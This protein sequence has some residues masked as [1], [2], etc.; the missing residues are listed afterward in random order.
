M[1]R[2]IRPMRLVFMGTP[3]FAVPALDA[4]I[5]AGHHIVCV[6]TQPPRR[7]GRGQAERPSPVHIHADQNGIKVRCPASLKDEETQAEFAALNADAAI[8]VAYGLILP[9]EIL[10]APRLGCLNIHASLLP[11]W[12]GAAPI[13]RAIMEGDEVT[14]VNIM[15]MDEGLDTGPIILGAETPITT[16]TSGGALHDSLAALGAVLVV[17]A[18]AGRD[19]GTLTATRQPESGATYARKLTRDDGRLDW[20]LPAETLE[21]RVRALSPLPGAWFNHGE[22]RIR[23]LEAELRPGKGA[24]GTVLDDHLTIG[25]GTGALGL[26]RVQRPGRNAMDAEDFL[27]GFDLPA[28]TDLG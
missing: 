8:V 17:E 14:G 22:E 7:A 4:L 2:P 16:D 20:S 3:D 28:G 6:Y 26:R 18:L 12:R 5:G 15:Q 13:Q 24:P 10:A 9:P 27:R 11:R 21:R 25:C 23:V 19:A 1:P